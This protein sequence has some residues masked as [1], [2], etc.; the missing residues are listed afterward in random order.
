MEKEE[1]LDVIKNPNEIVLSTGRSVKIRERKGQH[2]IVESRLLSSCAVSASGGAGVNIGDLILAA[3]IK[4]AVCIEEVDGKKVSIPKNLADV[5]ELANQFDY[6]EW[7][8]LKLAIQ[9]KKGLIEAA[10]KNLQENSGF[11]SE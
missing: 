6:D 7:D 10:A 3:E 1:A 4:L 8:E 11:D 9:P 5:Y 2:H